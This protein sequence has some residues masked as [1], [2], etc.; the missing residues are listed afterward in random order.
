MTNR[1][2]KANLAKAYEA[3]ELCVS[4][5]RSRKLLRIIIRLEKAIAKA[6]A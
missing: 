5:A 1:E 6:G 4:P 3:I 2:L